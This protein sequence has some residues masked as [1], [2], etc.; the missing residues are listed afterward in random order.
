[1]MK[2]LKKANRTLLILR[3]GSD[4]TDND[5]WF[6]MC[7]DSEN[8][9]DAEAERVGYILIDLVEY[10]YWNW[11]SDELQGMFSRNHSTYKISVWKQEMGFTMNI[12]EPIYDAKV[13]NPDGSITIL[14]FNERSLWFQLVMW[15]KF[16]MTWDD[17]SNK[18]VKA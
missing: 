10:S 7:Q 9:L 1:M 12:T 3:V 8:Y 14:G 16:Q 5:R 11:S 17:K 4:M 2:D 6:R 18:W 15:D 13:Q